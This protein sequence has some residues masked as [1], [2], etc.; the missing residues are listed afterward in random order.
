MLLWP[1]IMN[2]FKA[3]DSVKVFYKV[4]EGESFRLQPFEGIVLAIKGEGPSKTFLVRHIGPENVG[5]ER[6]FPFK[7][8]NLE[9][10]ELVSQGKVRRSK[11]YYLRQL[12]AK[13]V[14]RRLS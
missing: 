1:M 12:S 10:V 2:D 14:R 8:P 13:E 3:G 7:S 11:V 6:I 4:K 5:V 9:K